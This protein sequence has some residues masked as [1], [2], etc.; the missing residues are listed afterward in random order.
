[1]DILKSKKSEYQN[2]KFELW[3]R[4]DQTFDSMDNN[5]RAKNLNYKSRNCLV[6]D[7]IS[8]KINFVGCNQQ[9]DEYEAFVICEYD[10][11][12]AY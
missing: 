11:K 3:V 10:F 4:N 1:M 2:R 6:Y 8:D 9:V 12:S 7:Y 5:D